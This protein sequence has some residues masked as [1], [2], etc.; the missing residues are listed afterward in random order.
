MREANPRAHVNR[1]IN[2][3]NYLGAYLFLKETELERDEHVEL[4]GV[5]ASSVVDE[6]SRTRREDRER[7]FFLRSILGWIL[8]D[9]PGL[10]S[11]YRE[12]LRDARA[13]NDWLGS[14]SRGFHNARDMATGRKSVSEG[15]QEAADEAKRN[16]EDAAESIRSGDT[17][18]RL[19]EFL[20][21][22]ESG[23]RQGLDQL[24]AFFRTLN[25]Q[26]ADG[27]KPDESQSDAERAARASADR[28]VED[29]DFEETGESST[30]T[31]SDT[32]DS[33]DGN[34]GP[35]E[36]IHVERES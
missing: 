15:F 3:R 18:S 1:L 22:A 6:L 19:T 20:G 4:V 24:S 35:A 8:R 11:L 21:S 31:D 28:D 12:Q 13:G 36:D 9:V 30:T 5:L 27:E 10:G 32:S 23:I 7:I 25:E 33:G 16:W 14:V 2:E 26:A 17:G 34:N 29:A